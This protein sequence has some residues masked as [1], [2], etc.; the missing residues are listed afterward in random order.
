MFL[1]VST[2][3]QYNGKIIGHDCIVRA[4]TI[5]HEIH[6]TRPILLFLLS[7]N[8][9]TTLDTIVTRNKERFFLYSSIFKNVI[10]YNE[11]N[12]DKQEYYYLTDLNTMCE[13]LDQDLLKIEKRFNILLDVRHGNVK[14]RNSFYD[15]LVLKI[16]Y[17][18]IFEE[19]PFIVVHNRHVNYEGY[20]NM[21][22]NVSMTKQIVNT[23]LKLNIK[24][25]IFTNV[26]E[27][28][29]NNEN[30]V[31]INDVHTYATLM[32]HNKCLA[33]IS[34][35]SGAGQLSQY[36]HNKEI[37]YY[38]NNYNIYEN[39][40]DLIGANH[41]NNIYY[42]FDT[43]LFSNAVI[44]NFINYHEILEQLIKKYFIYTIYYGI[45]QNKINITNK[46]LNIPTK[47]II[48]PFGDLER[49]QLFGDPVEN[50]VKYIYI[51]KKDLTTERYSINTQVEI[52]NDFTIEFN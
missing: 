23:I 45:D 33:V 8:L 51:E 29:E 37:Y 43:K 44:Y 7:K 27:K 41:E 17:Y 52:K 5:G 4:N 1:I 48:I 21:E 20:Y 35:Y 9:I 24:V 14:I 25:Y 10:E 26:I 11:F 40:D 22:N 38:K 31:T 15:N 16:N 39:Y 32:N 47:T 28:F 49:A 42:K 2:T 12:E 30:V 13:G 19:K 50:V 6:I 18:T 3:P 34:E 46:L 36:C